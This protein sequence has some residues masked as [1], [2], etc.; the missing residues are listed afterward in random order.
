MKKILLAFVLLGFIIMGTSQVTN[1]TTV[2]LYFNITVTNTS[3]PSWTGDYCVRLKLYYNN[4][5]YV[6]S[7]VTVCTVQKSG[8][9]GFDFDD[10]GTIA[11]CK[12]G[13]IL[14]AASQSDGGNPIN[15][16]Q[17]LG[18][19]WCW[20]NMLSCANTYPISITL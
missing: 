2:R 15:P 11:D 19:G 7:Q 8:C 20:D 10:P 18:G 16:N 12:Y 9:V 4:G 1:A 3:N 13:V 6:T 5:A 14:V 17:I